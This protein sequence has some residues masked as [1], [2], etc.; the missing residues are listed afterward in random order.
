MIRKQ[1]KE[2]L[3]IPAVETEE[4]P[5]HAIKPIGLEDFV[6]QT[7]EEEDK[8]TEFKEDELELAK[9]QIE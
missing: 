2:E 8:E 6:K 9:K 4:Q 3:K 5:E 7:E 1:S